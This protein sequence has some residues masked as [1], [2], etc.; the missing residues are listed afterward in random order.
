L[1]KQRPVSLGIA[2]MLD[3]HA[4]LRGLVTRPEAIEEW[5]EVP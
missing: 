1:G 2:G 4:S 3:S 5:K